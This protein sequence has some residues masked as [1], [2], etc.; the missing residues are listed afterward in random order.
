MPSLKI[1]GL[2]AAT[3]V[4]ALSVGTREVAT[5]ETDG[6]TELLDPKNV[7]ANICGSPASGRNELFKPSL[8]LALFRQA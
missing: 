4:I 8:R 2:T 1:A 6:V 5:R 7:L 3:A